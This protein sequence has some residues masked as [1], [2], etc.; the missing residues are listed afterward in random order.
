MRSL[1]SAFG[2]A[3][4]L[5]L[6]SGAHATN[7]TFQAHGERTSDG[8]VDGT[9]Y[10]LGDS[11]ASSPTGVSFDA[12]SYAGDWGDLS[13][14]FSLSSATAGKLTITDGIVDYD[15][16]SF[17]DPLGDVLLVADQSDFTAE[18]EGHYFFKSAADGV[19]EGGFVSFQV[20]PAPEPATWSLLLL[21]V[22]LAGLALRQRIRVAPNGT[23]MRSP[24]Q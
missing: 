14:Y 11:G 19:P 18:F 16:F 20:S 10:G 23:L 5:I 17:T 8:Y 2:A 15:G 3:A 7:V 6:A 4:I 12:N 1:A 13:D 21:A 9:L 24:R 22:C